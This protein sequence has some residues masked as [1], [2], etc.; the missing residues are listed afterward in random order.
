MCDE[1]ENFHLW[2][3]DDQFHCCNLRV[4]CLINCAWTLM[5]LK[6][7]II[8]LISAHSWGLIKSW[9]VA[10]EYFI[11]GFSKASPLIF[12]LLNSFEWAWTENLPCSCRLEH[13]EYEYSWKKATTGENSNQ[14]QEYD[15]WTEY[16]Y[17]QSARYYKFV[18]TNWTAFAGGNFNRAPE[19]DPYVFSRRL[20]FFYKD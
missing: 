17:F 13:M 1:T 16:A 3:V 19:R 6:G 7:E 18:A 8:L 5:L 15:N 9:Y 11:S 20:A 12:Y 4:T 14:R 2:I 10:L